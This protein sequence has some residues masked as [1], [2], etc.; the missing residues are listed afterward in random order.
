MNPDYFAQNF[1]FSN[2]KNNATYNGEKLRIREIKRNDGEAMSRKQMIK[3]C[4]G[5]LSELRE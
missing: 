3:M 5:F 4:N 1:E 2:I